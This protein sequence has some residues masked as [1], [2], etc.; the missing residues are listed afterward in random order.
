MKQLIKDLPEF[1]RPREKAL[2][3]GI[4]SLSDVELLAIIIK[5]GYRDTSALELSNMLLKEYHSI[6]QISLLSIEKLGKYKGIGN[7]KATTILAAIELGKRAIKSN[8]IKL[9]ITNGDTVFNQYKNY[10]NNIYQEYLLVIF[11]NN[12]NEVIKDE[13]IFKGSI[14]QSL[15]HPREIFKKA[16]DYLAVKI[17]LVHNHPSGNESPSNEDD[18]FTYRMIKCGMMMGILVV[19][20]III[21]NNFYSYYDHKPDFFKYN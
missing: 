3:N 16:I 5:T 13:I 1:N 17:I 11:L 7:I 12:H 15:F 14:N 2:I 18:L 10:F 4:K 8:E 21:G 20:H 9:K 6:Y 19:D